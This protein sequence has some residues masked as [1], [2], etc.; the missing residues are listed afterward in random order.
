MKLTAA[1]VACLACVSVAPAAQTEKV[2]ISAAPKPGQTVHYAATQELVFEMAPDVPP[3]V[4]AGQP[5]ALPTMKMVGKTSLVFTETTGSPDAQGMVTAL[6]TYEQ[7]SADMSVNGI[8]MPGAGTLPDL[9]GKTF[10]LVFGADG[11]IA[12]VTAPPEMGAI[13]G[14]AKQFII[15]IYKLVPIATL[16]IGETTTAPFSIPLPIPIRGGGPIVMDGHTKTTLVSVD[17]EGAE[18][19][20]KCD[21]V[22]QAAMGQRAGDPAPETVSPMS[23]DM[24][25]QGTGTLQ[26][27]VDRGVMKSSESETTL[28]G[29]LSFGG[30]GNTTPTAAK[31]HGVIKTTVTGKY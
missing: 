5:S 28:D 4:P 30:S 1:A 3:D 24:K 7:A 2:T 29:A 21:Q 25:M 14:P 20:A 26:F 6:L 17:A 16:A 13:L 27:N 8:P 11:K 15:N 12:D 23:M 9:A 22:F 31:I 19:I 18:H 10:T